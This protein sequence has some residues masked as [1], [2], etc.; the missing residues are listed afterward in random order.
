[1]GYHI[2]LIRD[3]TEIARNLVR[4]RLGRTPERTYWYGKSMTWMQRL[5]EALNLFVTPWPEGRGYVRTYQEAHERTS[6]HCP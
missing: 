6:G 1:M 5:A 3:W 2:G 4:N